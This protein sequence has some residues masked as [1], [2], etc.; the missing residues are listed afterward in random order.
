MI[1]AA[2]VATAAVVILLPAGLWV[3][4]ILI[5]EEHERAERKNEVDTD[6]DTDP[7][8]QMLSG[9]R[10]WGLAERKKATSSPVSAAPLSSRLRRT[11]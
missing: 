3:R 8:D 11:G 9:M 6:T 2:I 1:A 5:A 10:E 4:A 7:F